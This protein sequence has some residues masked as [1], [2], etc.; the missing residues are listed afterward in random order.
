MNKIFQKKGFQNAKEIKITLN[1]K[2]TN[3]QNN[4]Y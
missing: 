3:T 2:N 1:I 4:V